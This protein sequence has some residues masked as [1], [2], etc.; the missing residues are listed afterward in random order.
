M[1]NRNAKVGVVCAS[2]AVGMIGLAYASVPLYRLF[3]QTTGFNG[4]TLRAASPSTLVLDQ[5]VRI[6]FDANVAPGLDWEFVAVETTAE[7]K[8]GENALAIY[9]VTNKASVAQ[10][11]SATFNVTP[12]Q[13]GAFFNKIQCFCFTEQR[14]EPGETVDMPVSFYVDPAI[15]SDP[16][17]RHVRAI[18]LS[19]TF[20]PVAKPKASAAVGAPVPAGEGETSKGAPRG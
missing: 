18:T 14:L 19:Y 9:R 5:N 4:A 10:V 13:A 3:C 1:L 6:R 2:V 17:G 7:L 15:V 8:I 11:G 12:E 20:H 16:D